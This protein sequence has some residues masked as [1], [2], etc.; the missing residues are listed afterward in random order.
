MTPGALI[1]ARGAGN[2]NGRNRALIPGPGH[3]NGDRSLSVTLDPS[4]PRGYHFTSFADDDPRAILEYVDG[5]IGR[6]F[7]PG[8][9]TAEPARPRLVHDASP[10]LEAE[11]KKRRA[12]EI[13]RDASPARGT[14]AEAWLNGRGIDLPP[15]ID[16]E[17][18]RYHPRCPWKSDD[19]PTIFVPAMLGLFRNIRSDEPQAIHRTRL[20][21][22]ARKTLAPIAGAAIKLDADAEVSHGLTI[23]EGIETCL[24]ARQMGL[25][26]VWA[27]GSAGGIAAFGPLSGIEALTILGEND[28]TGANP[29]AVQACA[30]LWRGSGAEVVL[31]KPQHGSDANDVLRAGGARG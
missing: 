24:A 29:R 22:K 19:G 7:R 9:R 20:D 25:R 27:L 8:E 15:E 18:L 21:V 13:W 31:L 30:R 28:A 11:R 26:P 16:G 2:L 5:L 6:S 17:V 3:S 23:G 14:Q 10:D 1:A 12:L 4:H